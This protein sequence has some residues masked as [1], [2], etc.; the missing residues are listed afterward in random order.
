MNSFE[1]MSD[2]ETESEPEQIV[3][4]KTKKNNAKKIK[5][6]AVATPPPVKPK[7]QL[8]EKQLYALSEGRKKRSNKKTLPE[9]SVEPVRVLESIRTSVE[10]VRVLESIRTSVEPV[11]VLESIRTSVEK[12]PKVVQK[13]PEVLQKA[14]EVLQKAPE[15]TENATD[16]T[17]NATDATEN[18]TDATETAP[19][20]KEKKKLSEKQILALENARNKRALTR[21]NNKDNLKIE[22]NKKFIINFV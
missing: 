1:P 19:K 18:A 14:P 21:A 8:T 6:I 22:N 11:R 4:E 3:L 5:E 16:A 7:K 17:E 15:A 13:A 9:T 20:I 12:A 10:P 2:S